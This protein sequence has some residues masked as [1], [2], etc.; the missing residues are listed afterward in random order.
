[1]AILQASAKKETLRG[2]RIIWAESSLLWD[3]GRHPVMRIILE[4]LSCMLFMLFI[5][6]YIHMYIY[7]H[8]SIHISTGTDNE[9]DK[10]ED[11]AWQQCVPEQR[12]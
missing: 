2:A 9:Y 5:R 4:L 12:T 8:V 10:S 1:M 3:S 7:V 6:V 11:E